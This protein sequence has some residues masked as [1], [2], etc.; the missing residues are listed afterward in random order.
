[1]GVGQA[2]GK[3][4][5]GERERDEARDVEGNAGWLIDGVPAFGE[6]SSIRQ[7][8]PRSDAPTWREEER[9]FPKA[10]RFIAQCGAA[11]DGSP[12]EPQRASITA[13][14]AAQPPPS[15]IYW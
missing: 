4:T 1:M 10:K 14:V 3:G 2:E 15:S 8:C 7:I 9:R 11:A 12:A 13:H 5:A 6:I